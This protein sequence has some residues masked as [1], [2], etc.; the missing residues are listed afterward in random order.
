MATLTETYMPTQLVGQV[1]ARAYGSAAPRLPVGNVLQLDL[2]H[3][4]DVQRQPD[5]TKGGGGT[6]AQTRRISEVTVAM[7]IADWNPLNFTR[8]VFGTAEEVAA[9][10]VVDESHVAYL[11]GLIRLSKPAPS[12]VTVK[13]G[14]ATIAPTNYEVRA[15]GIFIKADAAAVTD[16]DTL[17]VSY[18]SPEHVNIE[19]LTSSAPEIELSFGGL[20]EAMSGRPVIV[21][22]WRLG[23]GVA[24][25]LGLIQSA[26]SP[27]TVNGEVLIDPTKTGE[28][29]SRYYRAQ[30]V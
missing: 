27:I 26:M 22:I 24:A 3:T 15:E 28:G 6:Y 18:T 2:S 7:Q 9:G 25:Q 17:Q 12:L 13:K 29:I 1:Y 4:E 16:G 30:M 10:A 5:M 19:A 8:S 23:I 20:N 14:A 21:D 11:G